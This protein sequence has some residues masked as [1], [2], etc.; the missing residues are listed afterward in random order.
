[1]NDSEKKSLHFSYSFALEQG[2]K[3]FIEYLEKKYNL[4]NV[5]ISNRTWSKTS[6]W[7]TILFTDKVA[8]VQSFTNSMYDISFSIATWSNIKIDKKYID[9]IFQFY[10][11]NYQTEVKWFFHNMIVM[12][13]LLFVVYLWIKLMF[14]WVLPNNFLLIVGYLVIWYLISKM[15]TKLILSYRKNGIQSQEK[16]LLYQIKNYKFETDEFNF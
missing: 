5:N 13:I 11:L 15:Y 1:M 7:W 10:N 8:A 14:L 3:N 6:W 4:E 16:I 9:L 2:R 12:M